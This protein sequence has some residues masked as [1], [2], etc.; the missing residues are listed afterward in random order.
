MFSGKRMLMVLGA[1]VLVG[2]AFLATIL[3]L[4]WLA[5]TGSSSDQLLLGKPIVTTGDATTS[6]TSLQDGT[7]FELRGSGLARIDDSNRLN[8]LT[9]KCSLSVDLMFGSANANAQG[10]VIVGQ[11]FAGE[12]G[13]HLLWIPGQLYLQ[14]EGI[15]QIV[16]PFTPTPGQT[17][18]IKTMNKQSL[19]VMSINGNS[20]PPN[21]SHFTDIARDVTVGG[22]ATAGS[23]VGAN[24]FV[25]R[26]SNLQI[27]SMP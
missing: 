11:S 8:C 20:I 6:T 2:A 21:R 23:A 1:G 19:V 14:A 22:R 25:G 5:P 13:W 27:T 3:V 7:I 9:E 16:I 17:Y 24:F 12:H 18:R 4:N 10:E 15:T 26:V